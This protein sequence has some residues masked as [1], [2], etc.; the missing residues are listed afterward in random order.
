MF[1]FWASISQSFILTKEPAF[2][3]LE[4]GA[5]RSK[6]EESAVPPEHSSRDSTSLDSP[7]LLYRCHRHPGS[8]LV[9]SLFPAFR[10]VPSSEL[11]L[12]SPNAELPAVTLSETLLPKN[13]VSQRTVYL[14]W[15]ILECFQIYLAFLLL[16]A[17]LF[18]ILKIF[19]TNSCKSIWLNFVFLISIYWTGSFFQW[20]LCIPYRCLFLGILLSLNL[21]ITNI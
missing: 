19:E 10:L 15:G 12:G 7:A 3:V 8:D 11:C 4:D 21:K 5:A 2:T 18:F 13:Q 9:S 14:K 16:I 6:S 1:L 20:L 17:F